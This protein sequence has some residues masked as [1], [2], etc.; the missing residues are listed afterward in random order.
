MV[1]GNLMDGSWSMSTQVKF[2]WC[3]IYRIYKYIC[4]TQSVTFVYLEWM[5]T[6]LPMEQAD[7][8]LEGEGSCKLWVS[9]LHFFSYDNI[10]FRTFH[11]LFAIF[12]SKDRLM[13]TDKCVLPCYGLFRYRNSLRVFHFPTVPDSHSLPATSCCKRLTL[14]PPPVL[15]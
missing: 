5:H 14:F 13:A 10:W 12:F 8:D 2:P 1:I 11:N 15:I 4:L 6:T 3:G 9:A 7:K